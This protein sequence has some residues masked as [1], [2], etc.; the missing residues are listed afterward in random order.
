MSGQDKIYE[1]IN[2][3]IIELLESGEVP[4]NKPWQGGEQKNFVSKKAYRGINPF[5]LASANYACPYWVSFKQAKKLGGMVR[6]GEKGLP[7]IFWKWLEITDKN[8]DEKKTIPFLRYYTVFNLEQTDGIDIPKP[9]VFDFNP[10][11]QADKMLNGMPNRPP[12]EHKQA[13]AFYRPSDDL[14]N[15]PQKEL[16]VNPEEYYS[17]LFHELV[18]S[19]GHKSRLGRH[20]NNLPAYFG[21]KDYSKE[22]L[23][24]EFGSAF[25]C[26]HC[27][28]EKK[29]IDNSAAYISGWLKQL[30]NNK[31]WLVQSSAQAQKAADYIRGI[32]YDN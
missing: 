5:L 11:E 32:K 30:R 26:G 10:I 19:T 23:V 18:H 4:W 7:V 31:K 15:M 13:R 25:L 9:K 21:S 17:T 28:I 8:T 14:I 29:T 27:N 20:D 12:I 3:K 22:E 1:M 2:N 16:F 6:K 24:A